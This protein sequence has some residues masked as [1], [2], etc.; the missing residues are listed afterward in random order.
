L[1]Q[2]C[3]PPFGIFYIQRQ[4]TAFL[5]LGCYWPCRN[6]CLF[7]VELPTNILSLF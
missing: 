2:F 4:S 3:V 6:P 1:G 7:D 5:I